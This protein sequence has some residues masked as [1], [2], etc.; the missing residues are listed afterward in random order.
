MIRLLSITLLASVGVGACSKKEEATAVAA[1]TALVAAAPHS[2]RVLQL[3]QSG[4]YTYAEVETAGTQRV[5]LVG[6]PLQIEPGDNL[7]WGAYAVMENYRSQTLGRTFAQILFVN[8]WGPVGG[9]GL[10]VAPHGA[11]LG[12]QA[13]SPTPAP[14]LTAVAQPAAA[15][16]ANQGKV[17]SVVL[18]GGYTYL[19]IDQ[20]GVTVWLVAPETAVKSGDKVNWVDGAV[21]QNYTAKPLGRTFE[22]IIF[23]D[24]VAVVQ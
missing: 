24:H 13:Y 18:T 6:A 16:G 3:L 8:S 22:R 23:A 11:P 1:P 9:P 17:K 7:Q 19:E 14:L 20:D 2:G 10:Q 4:D 12:Q 5:W 15:A 21:I